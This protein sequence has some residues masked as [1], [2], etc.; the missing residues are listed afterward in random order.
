MASRQR[1]LVTRPQLVS[2]GLTH[3]VIDDWIARGR[4]HIVHR[5]VYAYGHRALATGAA[6]LAAVLA[7][8]PEAV[9]SHRSAAAHWD[10]RRMVAASV[11]VTVPG[12]GGHRRQPGIAIHRS[13][14]LSPAHVTCHEGIR[15]TT[16]ARTLVDLAE[17]VPRRTLERAVEQAEVVQR[18]DV[19]A[20]EAVFADCPQRIGCGRARSVLEAYSGG[21]SLTRSDLE[22]LFLS[23]CAAA[24]LP[25]PAVNCRVAGLEVDFLWP[26][27]R[28]IVEADSRRYHAT[29]RAFERD[30]ERDAILL[31]HGYRVVRFTERR[32][33]R[34]PHGVADLLRAL[35]VSR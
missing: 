12:R 7:S 8:G 31:L 27:Q 20:L 17:V 18:L 26:T 28:L 3:R 29:R 13:T 11:D 21:T 32:L 19:T 33:T 4:L 5:G 10:L 6:W 2:L 22:E 9:L 16:V 35:L 30:R 23:I 24:G 15:V 25:R 34:D 1:G 14:T